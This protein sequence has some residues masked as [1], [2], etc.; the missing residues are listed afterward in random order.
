MAQSQPRCIYGIHS[1]TPYNK[2]TGEFLDEVRVLA[3][4]EFALSGEVIELLGGSSRYPWKVA[5][6]RISAELTLTA[7]EYPDSFFE[8]L[9]GKKLT[10]TVISGGDLSAITNVKGATVSDSVTGIASIAIGTAADLR[11]GK[12]IV[13]A[14]GATAATLHV[15]SSVDG[16]AILDDSNKVADLDLSGPASALGID[17]TPGSGVAMVAGDTATFDVVSS[18]S[19]TVKEAVIGGTA[20]VYPE[21]GAI[22]YAQKVGTNDIVELDIF[23][24]KA[25]GMPINMSENAFSEYSVTM[26]ASYD[27]SKGGVFKYKSIQ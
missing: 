27:A 10:E 14:T 7:R 3:G 2:T 21:F 15:S 1:F 13:L 24:L 5:D 18:E 25:I 26:R 22:V 16:A 12:Y 11:T 19:T 6:G 23:A 9:L 17:F 4:S 8:L 20:D